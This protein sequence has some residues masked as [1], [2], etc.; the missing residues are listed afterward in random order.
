MIPALLP[1][2]AYS[3][4]CLAQPNFAPIP[5]LQQYT[6]IWNT[7]FVPRHFNLFI[8][9]ISFN[10]RQPWRLCGQNTCSQSKTVT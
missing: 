1:Q 3:R 4:P 7:S 5:A 6:G 10:V 2:S 8:Y 9:L